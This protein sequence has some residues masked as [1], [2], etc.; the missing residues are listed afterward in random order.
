[1]PAG[2]YQH[3]EKR[4]VKHAAPANPNWSGGPKYAIPFTLQ[5]RRTSTAFEDFVSTL[6][7][8]EQYWPTDRRIAAWVHAHKNH[9]YVPEGLLEALGEQVLF[10]GWAE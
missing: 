5:E 4:H 2:I 9:R 6:G 10:D 8:P 1:M 7:V 3:T